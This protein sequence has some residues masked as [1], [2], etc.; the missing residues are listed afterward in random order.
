MIVVPIKW[1]EHWVLCCSNTS[2]ECGLCL[3]PAA[4]YIEVITVIRM[5]NVMRKESRLNTLLPFVFS[6]SLTCEE[7]EGGCSC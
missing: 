7:H 3:N 1:K 6:I 4:T 5:R 2:D